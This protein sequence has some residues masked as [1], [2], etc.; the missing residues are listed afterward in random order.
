MGCGLIDVRHALLTT[1]FR[2]AEDFRDVPRADVA[3]TAISSPTAWNT[4]R[5]PDI[6]G[7]SRCAIERSHRVRFYAGAR[8]S[9]SDQRRALGPRDC[10]V[11][12]WAKALSVSSEQARQAD[13]S[14]R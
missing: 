11:E 10:N 12:C 13:A 3:F 14:G 5:N 4:T 7:Q 2:V 9:E 1:E 6:Q 8:P